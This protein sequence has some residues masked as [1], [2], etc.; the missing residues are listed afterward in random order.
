MII[1][2]ARTSTTDQ[3]AGMEAQIAELTAAGAERIYDEHISSVADVRP[4]LEEMLDFAR[5]GDTVTV[6]K[7]DRMARSVR[8]FME[9]QERL[10][11]KGAALKVLNLG[12]DTGTPTGKLILGTLSCIAQFER[13]IMLERQR[14]GLARAKAAGKCMGRK[15]TAYE[16]REM[17]LKLIQEGI[18]PTD[19]ASQLGIGRASVYRII[20]ATPQDNMKLNAT[21]RRW[22]ARKAREEKAD[23]KAA[24]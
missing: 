16:K 20:N 8:G 7:I 23:G 5:R 19:V 21:L 24:Q 6:T 9:I 11:K 17:V 14:E 2:Y 4:K 18:N 15:P 22:K 12:M 1:G 13:E 10:A 3:K